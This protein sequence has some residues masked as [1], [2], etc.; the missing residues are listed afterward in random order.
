MK[1]NM[2]NL[3]EDVNSRDRILFKENF[4]PEMYIG[5]VRHF[6]EL[7]LDN[8]ETLVKDKFIELDECQNDSPTTEEILEFVRKYP[9][10]LVHGYAVSPFRED[11]RVT[12]EGVEKD[13]PVSSKE[14]LIDFT[15]LFQL[16]DEF[17]VDKDY[18]YCWFD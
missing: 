4:N 17:V 15:K 9:D 11:Y 10:Y 6:R 13:I 7:S 12:L 1:N 8:L 3:N 14:E 16:A 18:V 2:S 5:G